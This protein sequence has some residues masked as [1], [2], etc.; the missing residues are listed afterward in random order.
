MIRLK[1]F[2]VFVMAWAVL[3]TA[4]LHQPAAHAAVACRADP[5]VVLSNGAVLDLELSIGDQLQDIQHIAY[6]LHGPVGT[7]MVTAL[8]PDGTGAIS[9]VTYVADQPG[10][11]MY[12]G[13]T[14]VTTG[15]PNRPV[16]AFLTAVTL[17]ANLGTPV[18]FQPS[19]GFSGQDLAVMLQIKPLLGIL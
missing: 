9:T 16:T 6:T 11:Y 8:Y 19:N 13:D 10:V 15:Q 1:R 2:A 7:S 14:T 5:V 12:S 17:P 3:C 4:L 18:L